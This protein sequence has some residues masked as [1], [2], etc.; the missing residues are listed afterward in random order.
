MVASLTRLGPKNECAGERQ[1]QL[2]M[3]DPNLSSERIIY[4]DYDRRCSIE[5]KK[6]G[7]ESQG[8]RHQDELIGGAPSVVK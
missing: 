6:S 5:K 3:I 8:A 4:K 2:Q 1:Q 7:R